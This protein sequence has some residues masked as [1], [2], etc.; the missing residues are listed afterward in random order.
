MCFEFFFVAIE[1]F[2]QSIQFGFVEHTEVFLDRGFGVDVWRNEKLWIDG[3]F[4]FPSIG[5]NSIAQRA[6]TK[7]F[8]IVKGVAVEKIATVATFKF[9]L[10]VNLDK[11]CQQTQF[12]TS[13]TGKVGWIGKSH[14]KHTTNSGIYDV[15]LFV[16]E[17][18]V[19]M[20]SKL[21]IYVGIQLS[22]GI[23][24]FVAGCERHI[25]T[26]YVTHIANT[27]IK[28]CQY[29]HV[30]I[31]QSEVEIEVTPSGSTH[32]N[33]SIDLRLEIFESG[34]AGIV[35][36][37]N[38]G[39]FHTASLCGTIEELTNLARNGRQLTV[40]RQFVT[41]TKICV[42]TDVYTHNLGFEIH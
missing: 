31:E 37:A 3:I 38:V 36:L 4:F 21:G 2:S 29:T 15:K 7:E 23:P 17:S 9:K 18:E 40:A 39:T 19:D 12:H 30:S 16:P 5:L 41:Y 32:H 10:S 25:H 20:Y 6:L 33:S 27:H 24:A 14:S 1:I 35:S 42:G 8:E 13:L 34:S 26:R 28:S 22:F 11:T